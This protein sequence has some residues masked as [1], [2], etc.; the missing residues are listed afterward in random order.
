MADSQ[1]AVTTQRLRPAAINPWGAPWPEIPGYRIEGELGRGGMGVV[2]RA[3]HIK[4][5]RTVAIKTLPPDGFPGAMAVNDA[6]TRVFTSK[7]REPNAVLLY[8]RMV[9]T[10]VT[11]PK[12][13][14]QVYKEALFVPGD[15][16]IIAATEPDDRHVVTVEL[17]DGKTGQ[18]IRK[19]NVPNSTG[20]HVA[21]SADG[22]RL[23]MQSAGLGIATVFD[24]ASGV[25]FAEFPTHS[26]DMI[27]AI[28]RDGKR[29]A[30]GSMD[31]L[32]QVFD[33]ESKAV[34]GRLQLPPP[35][36]MTAMAF[37]PDATRLAI[38]SASWA[39]DQ[40]DLPAKW[41]G[42]LLNLNLQPRI[43]AHAAAVTALCFSERGDRLVSGSEDGSVKVWDAAT[44]RE[45]ISMKLPFRDAAI[46]VQFTPDGGRL[47]VTG[48]IHGA[49][50]F[51]GKP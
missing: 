11:A 20:A 28:S 45:A 36:S 40:I 33:V 48:R 5:K 43:P 2:Y 16:Y 38:G 39:I 21:V 32:V 18:V 42:S 46:R 27:G 29:I 6:A 8:D 19:W 30:V 23:L 22:K 31:G 41:D 24:V 7:C 25:K 9:R 12:P 49:A 4:L 17:R 1:I 26:V 14:K 35:N 47:I 3:H 13:A 15:E 37:N 51:D 44:S 50:I 34:M 10:S